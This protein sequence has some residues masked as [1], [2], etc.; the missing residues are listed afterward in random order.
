MQYRRISLLVAAAS[1][2]AYACSDRSSPTEPVSSTTPAVASPAASN[3]APPSVA[4][5]PSSSRSTVRN[6]NKHSATLTGALDQTIGTNRLVGT[7][8]VT[9]LDQAQDGSLLA[10]GII[11]GVANGVEFTQEFSRIPA[12][13][14]GQGAVS[15]TQVESAV[16]G[17]G[18]SADAAAPMQVAACDI[19][20]LDLGPL[21]LDVLGLV[22]DLNEVV[23]D[24][25]AQ[26][27]GGN[28]LGNLLC[29]VVHLLDGPA[30]LA[31][32]A[33]LLNQI[34]AILGAV[35]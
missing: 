18:P 26:A 22:V 3:V 23:L 5:A 20:L 7:I 11:T 28:L 1:T 19:L 25:A 2:V 32:V 35:Q 8:R 24:I 14:R 27:G 29:A 13:L 10:S 4:S 21:H 16:V 6:G 33:N 31:A 15:S 17:S 12:T 9:R 30:I 34:N